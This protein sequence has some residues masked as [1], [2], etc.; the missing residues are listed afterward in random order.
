MRIANDSLSVS[1]VDVSTTAVSMGTSFNSDG[2]YLGHI[3]NYS[4]QLVF[5]GTPNGTFMLQ[6]SNDKGI[7]D[8]VGGWNAAGVTHWTDITGSDQPITGSGDL[9]W[10]VENAG[11]RW[12]RLVWTRSSSTGSLTSARVNAKG[13]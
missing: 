3:V 6:C 12:V 2:F 1:D 13:I 9:A 7:E 5:T 4:I 10:S 8:K 11:Y